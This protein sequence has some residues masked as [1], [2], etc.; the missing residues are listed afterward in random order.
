MNRLKNLNKNFILPVTILCII[1]SS[2]TCVPKPS[3]GF[4]AT[5]NYTIH[6]ITQEEWGGIDI[7]EDLDISP[8]KHSPK[9]LT[10]HHG[11]VDWKEGTDPNVYLRDLQAWSRSEK[12]WIDIPYHYMIDLEGRIYEARDPYYSGDTNTTYNPEGHL[13]TCL[14]GNYENQKPSV[15][16][17]QG[18]PQV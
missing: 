7:P 9:L 2:Y 10:L 6:I 5:E 8:V 4:P 16:Q 3:G 15:F 17:D 12:Q 11:G 13:L 18:Y 1:S 14:M